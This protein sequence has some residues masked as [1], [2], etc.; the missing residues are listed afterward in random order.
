MGTRYN[1]IS[2]CD[3]TLL[4]IVHWNRTLGSFAFVF[5]DFLVMENIIPV[6]YWVG[7]FSVV[8]QVKQWYMSNPNQGL[9][10]ESCTKGE[11]TTL[12]SFTFTDV[13]LLDLLLRQI[14]PHVRVRAPISLRAHVMIAWEHETRNEIGEMRRDP[15]ITCFSHLTAVIG[16]TCAVFSWS[17]AVLFAENVLFSVFQVLLCLGCSFAM[18]MLGGFCGSCAC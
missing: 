10:K 9:C 2:L 4:V 13:S 6:K 17:G 18:V 7:I 8:Y 15:I 5:T 14:G 12:N 16:S 3:V 11:R 1:H